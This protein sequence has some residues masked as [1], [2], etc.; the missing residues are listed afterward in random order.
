[1]DEKAVIRNP[2]LGEPDGVSL[3]TK[4]K[5]IYYEEDKSRMRYGDQT[6]HNK[7]QVDDA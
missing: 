5:S 4:Y 7:D 3:N 2:R 1:M 6:F